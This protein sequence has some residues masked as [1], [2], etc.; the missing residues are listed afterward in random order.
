[1]IGFRWKK[2][3]L[4]EHKSAFLNGKL[5][6]ATELDRWEMNDHAAS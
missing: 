6:E 3:G 4:L 5:L 2:N 1:M